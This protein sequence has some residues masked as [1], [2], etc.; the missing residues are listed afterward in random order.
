MRV[1]RASDGAEQDIGFAES[2]WVDTGAIEDFVDGGDG[3]VTTWYAQ[4][5]GTP[6][7]TQQYASAQPLI[8][9]NGSAELDEKGKP[10]LYFQNSDAKL[11]TDRFDR[12]INGNDYAIFG[13]IHH[14]D[15]QG[16]RTDL[17]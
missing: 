17:A 5:E 4:V 1:R 8:A 15:Y 16:K 12:E 3:H 6:N 7:L 9:R 14:F 11:V 13:V 10:T 2:G